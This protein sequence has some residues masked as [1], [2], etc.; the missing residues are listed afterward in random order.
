MYLKGSW[1]KENAKKF[2]ALKKFISNK[3]STLK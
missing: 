1:N 2:T 3:N